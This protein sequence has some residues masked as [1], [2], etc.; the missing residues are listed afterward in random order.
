MKKGTAI[1]LMILGIVIMVMSLLLILA[2]P[3]AGA[4][5]LA[6]GIFV[7]VLGIKGK[8][9]P[10]PVAQASVVQ[11][12]VVQ[13]P[14]VMPPSPPR[15]VNDGENLKVAGVSYRQDTI[16][17]LGQKNDD[18]FLSQNQIKEDYA[19]ER[20]YE[21]EFDPQ[22]VEFRYEPENE[23]DPNAIAIYAGGVHIGYVKKGSTAHI[24]KLIEGGIIEKAVCEISG[25]NYKYYDSDTEELEKNQG[26]FYAKVHLIL[27]DI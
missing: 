26:E 25:G 7:L 23:Y 12:P 15:Q 4:I 9:K 1:L 16:R 10:S 2:V 18:Y 27:K 24:R 19:D 6:F 14:T 17:S 11:A 5:F 8:K 21:Y 3:V 20:I 22:P 13:N